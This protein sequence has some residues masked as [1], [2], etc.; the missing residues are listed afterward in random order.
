MYPDTIPAPRRDLLLVSFLAFQRQ[1]FFCALF[2]LGLNFLD[3]CSVFP[4]CYSTALVHSHKT[5]IV[6]VERLDFRG[7][8]K[9]LV[10]EEL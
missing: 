9:Y 8:A 7:Q 2:E 6:G 3:F 4:V 10:F 1:Q 5:C